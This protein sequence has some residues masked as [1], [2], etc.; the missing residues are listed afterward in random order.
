M[1]P[2]IFPFELT[3]K[4][5]S[6]SGLFH[7][8]EGWRPTFALFPTEARTWHFENTSASGPIP[9]SKYWLQSPSS[10]N[11]DFTFS[12]FFDPGT[13]FIRLSPILAPTL[14]RI[15]SALNGSPAAFSS[16]TL[17]TIEPA[18]VTPQALTACKSQGAKKCNLSSSTG[19]PEISSMA[20]KSNPTVDLMKPT[21]SSISQISQERGASLEVKSTTL[22][23]LIVTTLGPEDVGLQ[24]RPK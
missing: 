14:W 15:A 23:F 11:E 18:K 22:R 20:P 6:G 3:A 17:S 8:D 12:A 10:I 9:T 19:L 21:G 7:F 24:T 2:T 1:Q 16:I 5:I 13:I 4:T